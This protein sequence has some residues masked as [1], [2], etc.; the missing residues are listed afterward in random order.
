[1]ETKIS[2]KPLYCQENLSV[3]VVLDT[4]ACTVAKN[5]S[6]RNHLNPFIP[7][8]LKWTLPLNRVRT[9][10]PSRGLSQKKK[11]KKKKKEKQQCVS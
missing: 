4:N 11:R 10:V 1:M 2:S 7:E 9:I 6:R 8:F 5:I 3:N